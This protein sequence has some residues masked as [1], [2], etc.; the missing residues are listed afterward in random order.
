M[1]DPMTRQPGVL[2]RQKVDAMNGVLG[3]MGEY[4]DTRRRYNKEG[5][6]GLNLWQ[7]WRLYIRILTS[8][9]AY[10]AAESRYRTVT[11]EMEVRGQP[12]Q[13]Q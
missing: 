5:Y 8:H 3:T 2:E 10:R 13:L 7:S 12:K 1:G 4:F 11:H 9:T 6:D